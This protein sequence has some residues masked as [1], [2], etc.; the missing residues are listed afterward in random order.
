MHGRYIKAD[1]SCAHHSEAGHHLGKVWRRRDRTR[2][3]AAAPSRDPEIFRVSDAIRKSIFVEQNK[4]AIQ[5]M[6]GVPDLAWKSRSTAG[7]GKV[8]PR[9]K[10]L[11]TASSHRAN[12][13]PVDAPSKV[14]AP[15]SWVWGLNLQV[16]KAFETG[17]AGTRQKSNP[18]MIDGSL[19]SICSSVCMGRRM[20]ATMCITVATMCIHCGTIV[21]MK[22]GV[23]LQEFF[24]IHGY[25]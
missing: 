11:N 8:G 14:A 5:H 9:V 18:D 19:K 13:H 17:L 6:Q 23:R 2:R 22:R 4:I 10:A 7:V 21:K 3:D 12:W 15:D 16:A 1:G 24:L 20:E 25:S